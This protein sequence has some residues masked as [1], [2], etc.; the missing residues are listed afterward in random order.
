MIGIREGN[1]ERRALNWMKLAVW[2]ARSKKIESAS[3]R[4]AQ[5]AEKH[6]RDEKVAASVLL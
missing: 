3:V 6:E 4:Q 5:Q 1:W 2:H